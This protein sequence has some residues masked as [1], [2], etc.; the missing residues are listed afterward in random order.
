MRLLPKMFI[1][2]IGMRSMATQSSALTSLRMLAL[3]FAVAIVP[4][5]AVVAIVVPQLEPGP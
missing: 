2:F 3:Y 4:V 5:W 1:P